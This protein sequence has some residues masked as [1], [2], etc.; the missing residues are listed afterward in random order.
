MAQTT[1]NERINF[2][3]SALNFHFFHKTP[4]L[5]I[6][7]IASFPLTWKYSTDISLCNEFSPCRRARIGLIYTR[8]TQDLNSK[9]SSFEIRWT[10]TFAYW[11]V[12]SISCGKG[13]FLVCLFVLFFGSESDW[14]L[15]YRALP[16]VGTESSEASGEGDAVGALGARSSSEVAPAHARSGSSIL[17]HQEAERRKSAV[18]RQRRGNRLTFDRLLP[19]LKRLHEKD[20]RFWTESRSCCCEDVTTKLS[21]GYVLWFGMISH[22][23]WSVNVWKLLKD[24]HWQRF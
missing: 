15:A 17:Q 7:E 21:K 11:C 10:L 6:L 23:S 24:Q 13:C 4:T 22:I 3:F 1:W 8:R 19:R 20:T 14:P 12:W 18:R 5:H 9:W 16:R 2:I